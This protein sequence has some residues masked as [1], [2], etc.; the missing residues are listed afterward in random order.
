MPEMRQRRYFKEMRL[1][2]L[3]GLCEVARQGSFAA[4]AQTLRISR[5]AIWQQVRALEREFGASLVERRGRKA[6]LT[7]DG[8]LLLEIVAPLVTG[9]D[10]IKTA[11]R[12]R[13]EEL[14]RHLTV[15]TTATLLAYELQ[16]PVR[17]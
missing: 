1:Q 2:Q 10:G 4:A 5:P 6:E 3:R 12:D 7:G 13:R 17:E 11:F 16:A 14:V 15:A 9:F 8:R